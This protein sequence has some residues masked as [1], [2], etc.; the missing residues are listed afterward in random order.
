MGPIMNLFYSIWDGVRRLMGLLLPFFGKARD[1]RGW[2]QGLR[3][4]AHIVLL[5]GVVIGLAIIGYILELRRFMAAPW[6]ILREFWLPIVFLLV[7]VLSWLGWWLWKLLG[8]EEADSNFP[9]IDQAWEE[10]VAAL[11]QEGI[12]LTEAPLFLVL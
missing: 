2:G 12:D 4:G 7:Y 1:F 10:A 9:D 8:P 5:A 11:S 6:W 3:W